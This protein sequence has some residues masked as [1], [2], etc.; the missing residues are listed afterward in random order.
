[1]TEFSL[2][3]KERRLTINEIVLRYPTSLTILRSFHIDT[4]CNGNLTLDRAAERAGIA[5]DV[6]VAAL[7]T[8]IARET[9]R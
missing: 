8:A 5:L 2:S 4:C 9:S 7:E 3:S 6:L 1:M